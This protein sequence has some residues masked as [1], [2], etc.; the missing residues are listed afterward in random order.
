MDFIFELLFEIIVEGSVELSTHKKVPMPLRILA[1]AVC[2]G[3]FLLIS[4]II[5]LMAFDALDANNIGAT[6][7]LFIIGIALIIGFFY[8]IRKTYNENNK[9]K[10]DNV[11]D[12]NI[13][14]AKPSGRGAIII[15][16]IAAIGII[17]FGAYILYT[18]ELF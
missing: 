3:V 6:V 16:C 15:A 13:C 1:F 5:L 18:Y 7:M 2:M 9:E 4:G 8:M 11:D 14:E 12:T 10:N 17:V